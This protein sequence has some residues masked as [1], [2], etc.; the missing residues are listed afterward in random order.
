MREPVTTNA[1]LRRNAIAALWMLAVV[2]A[3][4]AVIAAVF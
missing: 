3:G 2:M 4:A 1:E